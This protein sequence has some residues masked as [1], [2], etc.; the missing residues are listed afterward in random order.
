MKIGDKKGI[1]R[2]VKDMEV[3]LGS[4]YV[5]KAFRDT[6]ATVEMMLDHVDLKLDWYTPSENAFKFMSFIRMCLGEEPENLNSINHYFFIDCLFREDSVMPYF[7][8]RNIRYNQ[9]GKAKT[10]ILGTREFSKSVILGYL[11]LFMAVE[12]KMPGFGK[13]N[14]GMYISDSMDKNV[15][16]N[17]ELLETLYLGSA[18]LKSI[19]E[20][21]KFTDKYIE[22]IRKPRT[23]KELK[24]YSAHMKSGGDEKG[25]PQ[26]WK[27]KFKLQGLGSS[28]GRGSGSGVERPQFAIF[29]D[30]VANEVD[31][32]SEAYL[33][34]TD[35]TINSDVG[36]SLS[37]NGHFQ[38]IIGTAYHVN[39]PVY[40]RLEKGGW[41]P[42]VFPKAEEA[43]HSGIFDANGDIV[44]PPVTKDKFVSVW[45]DRHTYEKQKEDYLDAEDA[46]RKGSSKELKSINQEY[47]I[48]VTSSHER[49]IGEEHLVWSDMRKVIE[50]ANLYN[51]YV[52]TDLTTSANIDSNLSVQILWAVDYQENWYMYDLVGRKNEINDQYSNILRMM[53]KPL[54][55]KGKWCDVGV[56]IDGQQSL[57]IIAL[58]GY[59]E[60]RGSYISYA[61][62]AVVGAKKPTWTGIRSKGSGDKLWRLKLV[63]P[64]F[65]NKQVFL[66]KNI[67]RTEDYSEM[68]NEL[69]MTTHTAIK[70]KY[71]DI[72]D[73]IS[74]MAL[75]DIEY[76]PKPLIDIRYNKKKRAVEKIYDDEIFGSTDDL[77][78]YS[79]DNELSSYLT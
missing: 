72:L 40:K 17:M 74:Q 31:A 58:D 28:G 49:L 51:W 69:K 48:R 42:L 26:R 53:E 66:N 23:K 36:R 43:P 75:I 14:F 71:D 11:I 41:L 1:P 33:D 22:L 20:Y 12:G 77:G 15:K 60:K 68:S 16:R 5:I 29:D 39:D 2:T 59:A 52:T 9:S 30:L 76:P 47:Y 55:H 32:Y 10:A 78:L 7:K 6:D 62:Q 54:K 64:R 79:S 25:V 37:G 44:V 56:E 73:G 70:S 63:A 4:G 45:E 19:F 35:S 46:Y 67:R 57:H 27:R 21:S 18:Y 50:N 13:V 34:S 38:I 3:A 65:H 24:V 61:K 8:V